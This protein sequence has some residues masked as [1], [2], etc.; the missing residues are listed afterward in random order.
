MACEQISRVVYVQMNGYNSNLLSWSATGRP[1]T[2]ARPRSGRRS[3]TPGSGFEHALRR[4]AVA[5]ARV[6][7]RAARG[8][9]EL[10]RLSHQVLAESGI[11]IRKIS[12]LL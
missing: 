12:E 6:R 2:W 8:P 11:N 9:Q 4:A 1:G 10:Q 3:S 7:V 5:P